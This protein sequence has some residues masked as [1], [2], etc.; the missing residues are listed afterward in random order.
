[1]TE[2][3]ESRDALEDSLVKAVDEEVSE[4]VQTYESTDDDADAV[5][6]LDIQMTSL[7]SD[8]SIGN[9]TLSCDRFTCRQ[10]S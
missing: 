6:R 3:L 5:D 1:M 9:G 4:H 8:T 2:I 10:S 7:S